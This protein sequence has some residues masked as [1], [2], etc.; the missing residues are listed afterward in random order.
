MKRSINKKKLHLQPMRTERIQNVYKMYPLMDTEVR[1]ELGKDRLGKDS[2]E[3]TPDKPAKS[4]KTQ[5]RRILT[6]S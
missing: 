3:E 1:L 6:Y 2:K 5:T 4:P